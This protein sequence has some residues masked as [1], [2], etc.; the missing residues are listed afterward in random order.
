MKYNEFYKCHVFISLEGKEKSGIMKQI[1]KEMPP[2]NI[3]CMEL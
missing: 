3:I 2:F 1:L